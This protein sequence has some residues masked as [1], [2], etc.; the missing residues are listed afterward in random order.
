MVM[1]PQRRGDKRAVLAFDLGGTFI[2]LKMRPTLCLLG[3]VNPIGDYD[4]S[5]EYYADDAM[6]KVFVPANG[7]S[8][9]NV[10]TMGAAEE[11]ET[12]VARAEKRFR[13]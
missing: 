7:G 8:L 5:Y 10:P 11:H 4:D 3:A 13:Q 1:A 6:I 9:V 12:V 2:K